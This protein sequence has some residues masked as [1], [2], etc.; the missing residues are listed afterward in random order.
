MNEGNYA[1]KEGSTTVAYLQVTQAGATVMPKGIKASALATL[2]DSLEAGVL[3]EGLAA[4][5][6]EVESG[7]NRPR[8]NW[9]EMTPSL[10]KRQRWLQSKQDL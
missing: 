7:F 1:I 6:I 10:S 9:K 5:A 2:Q 4:T 8:P 3:P